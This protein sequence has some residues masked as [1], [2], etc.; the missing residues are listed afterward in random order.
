MPLISANPPVDKVTDHWR[1]LLAIWLAAAVLILLVWW[2]VIFLVNQSRAR[3]LSAAE[4]DLA[5]ITRVSQGHASRT[6]HSADQV[7]RFVQARYLEIGAHLDLKDL[8]TRGVIDAEIFH[9]VGV[10]SPQ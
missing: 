5:N 1:S 2:Q 10:I 7:I 6:L 9:Q 4:R 3:E 8:V